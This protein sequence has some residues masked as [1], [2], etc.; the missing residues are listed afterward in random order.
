MTVYHE[1]QSVHL[2][3]WAINFWK[4]QVSMWTHLL[5][6]YNGHTYCEYL[7]ITNI[8]E[9]HVFFVYLPIDQQRLSPCNR[10]PRR[11]SPVKS[12]HR[13]GPF[14]RSLV[15]W[16]S[17]T[18]TTRRRLFWERTLRKTVAQIGLSP[19]LFFLW[20]VRKQLEIVNFHWSCS[21][22][23][24]GFVLDLFILG[25]GYVINDQTW[26]HT[27]WLMNKEL[28]AQQSC[29]FELLWNGLKC[30]E[31]IGCPSQKTGIWSI[32][33]WYW[34]VIDDMIILNK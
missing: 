25:C 24:R 29:K 5:S 4:S 13:Y 21:H 6:S 26:V 34:W 10:D 22:N 32:C 2:L 17:G 16:K 12:G 19:D 18:S 23:F 9:P 11:N 33:K 30:F 1:M 28:R 27:P 14:G 8:R 20:R 7:W 3:S 31:H 15:D